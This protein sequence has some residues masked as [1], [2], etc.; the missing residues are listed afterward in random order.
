MWSYGG[1]V[2]AKTNIDTKKRSLF[3]LFVFTM[4]IVGLLGRLFYWQIIK[5]KQYREEA[6]AQQTKNRTISPKRGVI[7]DRNG[8]ILAESISV[9][10][11]SITPKNIKDENKEKTA[12]GLAEILNL[13]YEKVLEKTKKNTADEIIAKKLDKEITNKLREWIKT[14][15]ISGINIYE[16]TKRYYPNG[17]LLSHILGFCGTDNQGLEGIE[18]QYENIL[19]GVPGQLIVGTDAHGND[20]PLNDEKY[21]P[22]EDGLSLVLTIDEMTQYIVEKYLEQAVRDNNPDYAACT[23][24]EPKTGDILAMATAPDF[25]PNDPFTHTVESKVSIW[26]QLTGAEKTRELQNLWRNKA[27]TDTF[28]PGSVFKAV[29]AA[30]A[31]EEGLVSDV[32]LV[33]F[34]CNGLLEI[35]GWPMKCW[36]YYNPHG[37][38]SL[39][40]G[41]M[42]SCNP[43]FMGISLN[44]GKSKFYNYLSAL[45]ISKKTGVDLPGEVNGLIHSIENV[46]DSTIASASFGQGF[47]VTQLNMLNALSTFG[48]DGVMMKPRIVSKIVDRDGN[49]VQENPPTA[50]KQVFSEQTSD[51]VLDMMKSVV[52]D[53]TGRNGQ[54]KGYYIAGK[55]STAEQGRGENKT[56]AASFV[57]LAPADDPQVAIMVTIVNPKGDLGHQGGAI[58]APVVSNILSEVL[59]YMEVKKDYDLESTAEKVSVPDVTNRTVGEAIRILN[60]AGLKYSVDTKDM[61][62]IVSAQMPIHGEKLVKKSLVRLYIEGNDTRFNAI[63]PNVTKMDVATATK[64]LQDANLNIKISGNGISVLQ[65]P[66]AGSSIEQGSVVRVEFR[67]SG[68]DVE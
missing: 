19:K 21:I 13:D 45:G 62:A 2:L 29:T 66:P 31:L 28:E 68:V 67:P 57:A 3:I 25:D 11:V 46:T 23:I 47:T 32:D 7:Y 54:V 18:V 12:K 56:Y 49:I 37:K 59:E 1:D 53:G 35:E 61:N 50:V 65:D 4:C 9:E 14:E 38:Q 6:Y 60:N 64:K 40:Q 55:T 52:S 8:E 16:D 42:N 22:A 33:K 26:S 34:T 27:I 48:N 5:G 63:V 17:A 51:S 43:V 41:L 30:I 10:S 15:K 36:R 39:R 58:S 20:L 44:I 24:I